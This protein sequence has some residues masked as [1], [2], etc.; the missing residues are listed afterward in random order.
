MERQVKDMLIFAK[1]D[2]I[3]DECISI[4]QLLA[5]MKTAAEVLLKQNT[6]SCSWENLT[7]GASIQCNKE[8]LVGALLNLVENSLQS[9]GKKANLKIRSEFI[10]EPGSTTKNS[11]PKKL[12]LYIEDSGPGFEEELADQLTEPFFTTKPRGTG[13]GLAVAQVVAK[14]HNGSFTIEA[15]KGGGVKAGFILPVVIA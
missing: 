10:V 14:A 1:G 15:R 4:D 7:P 13:L 2:A 3:L 8:S 6:S 5:E 9:A 11:P 12:C